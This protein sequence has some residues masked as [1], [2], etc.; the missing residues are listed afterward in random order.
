M[1]G[2]L[3]AVNLSHVPAPDVVETVSFEQILAD[4]IADLT[5]RAPEFSAL[6]ESDPAYKILEVA[7]Y[8]ETII[9]QRVNDGARAVMLAYARGSD[10]DQIGANFGVERRV[11]N[12][13]D[14]E[15]VPPVSP[16]LEGDLEFRRRIQLSL[17]G[18]STAGPVGAYIYH[19]LGAHP[20]VLDATV[21]SPTPGVV[22]VTVLSR[23]DDGVPD[24]AILSAVEAALTAEDVRPLTDS[25]AVQAATIVNYSIDATLTL[26][27]G[28][29]GAI[30]QAAAEAALQ[31]Y[32]D[33]QQRLGRDVARSGLL[34]ALHRPGVQNVALASPAA[35]VVIADDE[36]SFCTGVSVVVGGTDV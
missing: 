19:A 29:D 28:P 22:V 20:D 9:R 32:I 35:D 10:L 33:A 5:S 13:G 2:T 12:P 21:Q 1:V 30:V 36:A 7:A 8:R 3:T 26:Y 31:E 24:V 6:L 23:H 16:T 4:M 34:A 25:V 17:E 27:P 14:H 11:I 18:F 15:A